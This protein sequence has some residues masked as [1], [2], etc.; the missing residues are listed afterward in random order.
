MAENALYLGDNL[1]VLRRNIRDES[2]DLIYLDPPFN[3]DQ[4]Y[5]VRHLVGGGKRKTVEIR[6]FGDT[7]RWDAAAEAAHREILRRPG[8]V[9]RVMKA[10]HT[11]LGESEMMAYLV[12]M[13]PRL[14]ELHRVLKRSGCVYLHCDA[15]AGH[16]LKMLMDAVFGPENFLNEI[17]WK[18]THAHGSARRWGPVHDII[19]FYSK[20]K[21]YRWYGARKPH[22]RAYVEKHFKLVDKTGRRFQA[23]T[24][25]GAGTTK[26]DSGK[27]WRGVDPTTSGR[28]WAMP[29]AILGRLKVT[30]RTIQE[31]LDA[32]DAAGRIYWP[33]KAGGK[34]RLK[35][36]AD[37]LRGAAVPDVWTDIPPVSAQS[38]ERLGY[39]TQKPLALLERVISASS[40][41]GDTVLDPFCG[42]G[43]TIV[44]AQRLN[45]HW[46]G[47]DIAKPAIDMTKRRLHHARGRSIGNRCTITGGRSI[48]GKSDRRAEC[49]F[50]I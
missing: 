6:A 22:S 4:D 8:S 1:D 39:P 27:P 28:H 14:V 35:W 34:P 41:K 42:C 26:G 48:K 31:K 38:A 9:A 2:V 20:S 23:I 36:F 15:S 5:G 32:L 50:E 46:I 30:G 29:R 37:E 13:A 21:E 47:I 45:R 25:T 16:Y 3:S 24:L 43:T 7:W 40:K 18:R 11:F 19:L 12:M 33:R 44:A 17:I 49:L 10:F